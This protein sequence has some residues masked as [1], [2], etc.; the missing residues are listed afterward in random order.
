MSDKFTGWDEIDGSEVSRNEIEESFRTVMAAAGEAE[1]SFRAARRLRVRKTLMYAAVIAALIISPVA[2]ILYVQRQQAGQDVH[3]AE[4]STGKGEIR[5]ITLPDGSTVVLNAESVLL[6]P[7]TFS[8][9]REVHLSGEAIFDVTASRTNPFIVRTS[10]ISVKVHGTVFSVSA[11]HDGTSATATLCD[12]KV[13]VWAEDGEP[14]E[15]KPDQR[16]TYDREKGTAAVENVNAS[17]ATAWKDG[18]ICFRSQSVHEVFSS[19]ERRFGVTVYMDSEEYD[20]ALLTA[21]FINGE[22]LEELLDAICQLV[23]GMEYTIED[24][25]I[26]IR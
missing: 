1:A 17:E 6:Y 12:G 9:R 20:K 5:E 7:E 21:K 2:S 4:C 14:V 25:H 23:P 19:I 16:F 11:Y 13:S 10:D 24:D 18:G 22:S 3:I 8:R 26:Y 15:L